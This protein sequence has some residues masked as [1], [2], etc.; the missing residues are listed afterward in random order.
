[1]RLRYAV[2]DGRWCWGYISLVI[3]VNRAPAKSEA[4]N[5]ISTLRTGNV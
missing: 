1:M 2:D 5:E 3:P 4:E